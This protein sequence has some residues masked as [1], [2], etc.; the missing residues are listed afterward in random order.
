MARPKVLKDGKRMTIYFPAT[1][2]A[3]LDGLVEKYGVSYSSI[4]AWLIDTYGHSADAILRKTATQLERVKKMEVKVTK[5]E[6][7]VK[8]IRRDLPWGSIRR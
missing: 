7:T 2:M 6:V 3:Q 5:M 4:I 1:Q 8:K